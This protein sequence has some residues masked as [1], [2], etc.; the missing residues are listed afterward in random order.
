[1]KGYRDK[2]YCDQEDG[3]FILMQLCPCSTRDGYHVHQLATQRMVG[4]I[5]IIGHRLRL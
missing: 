2:R 3:L 1:M 4:D 5:Y